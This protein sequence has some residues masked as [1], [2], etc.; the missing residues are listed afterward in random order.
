MGELPSAAA[1]PVTYLAMAVNANS[2]LRPLFALVSMKG[3][4]Y[5]CGTRVRRLTRGVPGGSRLP[6][7]PSSPRWRQCQPRELAA[8]SGRGAL[9]WR[10]GKAG[11]WLWKTFYETLE[12]IFGEKEVKNVSGGLKEDEQMRRK[13][14]A[15]QGKKSKVLPEV[16][17]LRLVSR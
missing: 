9:P 13:R 12:I 8:C 17:W 1:A 4:P 2:T 11:N 3:T 10:A 14:R 15:R 16:L 7:S 6:P 5:S